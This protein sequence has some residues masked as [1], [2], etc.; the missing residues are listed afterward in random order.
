MAKT[1]RNIADI[2]DAIEF[3]YI[4]GVPVTRIATFLKMDRNRVNRHITTHNLSIRREQRLINME[5]KTLAFLPVGY[6]VHL[7]ASTTD[8]RAGNFINPGEL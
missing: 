7:T 8:T 4:N 5:R 3:M 1:V 6:E 2:H